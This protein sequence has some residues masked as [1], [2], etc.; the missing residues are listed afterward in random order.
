LLPWWQRE[1]R[2]M[3]LYA[4][5]RHPEVVHEVER[6]PRRSLWAATFE[7]ASAAAI[8]HTVKAQH[9]VAHAKAIK[10]DID[11]GW[12]GRA[13]PFSQPSRAEAFTTRLREAGL[14]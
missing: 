10:P 11:A 8:G 7:A 9:A 6:M 13:L 5:D 1:I 14:S 12:L 2:S 3:V 4:G